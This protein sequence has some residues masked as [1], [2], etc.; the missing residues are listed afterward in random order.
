MEPE[1]SVCTR[2][3]QLVIWFNCNFQSPLSSAS[4]CIERCERTAQ[5]VETSAMCADKNYGGAFLSPKLFRSRLSNEPWL[6]PDYIQFKYISLIMFLGKR[7][8][9]TLEREISLYWFFTIADTL[10]T[11]IFI[12][13]PRLHDPKMPNIK[14]VVED[15]DAFWQDS[16]RKVLNELGFGFHICAYL[17]AIPQCS[18]PEQRIFPDRARLEWERFP[19]AALEIVGANRFHRR[20]H[21]R[22]DNGRCMELNF[23]TCSVQSSF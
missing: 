17:Y 15:G 6:L 12:F 1:A 13:V 18:W 23:M 9:T 21:G 11:S 22:W 16:H 4:G 20:P 8:L 7:N 14:S 2:V 5:R 19:F 10:S 3:F